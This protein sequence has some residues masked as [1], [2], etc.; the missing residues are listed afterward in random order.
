MK[1]SF[2]K[3]RIIISRCLEFDACRYNGLLI[4]DQ[5]IKKMKNFCDFITVCPE[6]DIGM[7]TPRKSISII[8]D[9]SYRLVQHDTNIDYTDKMNNFSNKYLNE[10]KDIDG[11]I[12]KNKSPS[13]GINSA[14]V[15]KKDNSFKKM[16]D[17]L[18]ASEV[19]KKF[20]NHPKEE[21]K[22]LNNQ[23]LREHFL[24]SIYILAQFRFLKSSGPSFKDLYEFQAKNKY[25]FLTYN[26]VQMRSLGKIAANHSNHSITEVIKKYESILFKLIKRRPSFRSNL[27]TLEHVFGHFSNK[28]SLKERNF[29]FKTMNDYEQKKIPLS[30]VCNLIFS[31]SIRFNDVYILNQSYFR[32][33]PIELIET[34]NSRLHL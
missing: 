33:F 13:C 24:T 9:G 21:E 2:P 5:F 31:W 4:S 30:S 23:Y 10:I 32:P 3:P 12:L 7:G 25:L 28:L 29:F 1:Q 11:F 17:G 26:Q 6:V 8:D 16:G 15:F 34:D 18:F 19:K 14:R 22:R 27:N 20:P